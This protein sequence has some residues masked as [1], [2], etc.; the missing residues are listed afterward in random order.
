VT[1]ASP[2]DEPRARE[3]GFLR[4]LALVAGRALRRVPRE[5]EA[6][7]PALVVPVFFYAINL[8]QFESVARS[9]VPGS[10]KAFLLPGAIVFAITGTSRASAL[11]SDIQGGYFDRLALTPVRRT[12]LLLGHMAADV[13]L[14]AALS[15]PVV[16]MGDL[17]G[18]RFVT[19]LPGVI[20]F[21]LLAACWALG[22]TG[23]LYAIALA[24][25]S[26]AAVNGAFVLFFP[27]AFLSTAFVPRA[28]L[29][30]WM[31]AVVGDNPVTYLL[32]ALRSLESAGWEPGALGSALVA[33]ASVF[34]I[35]LSLCLLALRHRTRPR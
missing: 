1:R 11:V 13:V 5:P 26:P 7:L 15:V 18:V 27:F 28:A 22:F 10:F 14:A 17:V 34:A 8:G 30:G 12:A 3:I 21:V 19:G 4:S 31:S 23:F 25:G 20:A 33:I 29:T 35:S 9:F 16:V 2:G 6:V 32:A 24:T